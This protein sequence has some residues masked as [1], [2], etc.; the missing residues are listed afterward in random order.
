MVLGYYP[1]GLKHKGYND[2][3]SANVN[4]VAS[5]F[6]YNGIELEE[7]LGIDWYEM[8]VRQYDPAIAR[9]TSIDPVT[10]YDFST[11]NAFDN[12]PVFWADP[13]GANAGCPSCQ[14]EEDWENYYSQLDNAAGALGYD[15]FE[16]ASLNMDHLTIV[17]DDDGHKIGMNNGEAIDIVKYDNQ[18]DAISSFVADGLLIEAPLLLGKLFSNLFKSGGDEAIERVVSQIRT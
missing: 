3:V 2:V 14:T 10:H 17:Y 5:R 12:N 6:K 18:L 11:Y 9:F 1:F 13:S 16:Q 4:S 15:S 7:S 8:D